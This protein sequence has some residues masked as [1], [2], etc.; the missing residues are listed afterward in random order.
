MSANVYIQ[1]ATIFS[2][3]ND[4]DSKQ[5]TY[6][7]SNQIFLIV[8]VWQILSTWLCYVFAKFACKI[9]IQNF[10]FA[11][12]V[13][14]T[15]PL[16]I[17]I[18]LTVSGLREMNQCALHGLFEDYLFFSAPP[19]Y[20]IGDFV[21]K[22]YA[23]MWLLTIVSQAWITKHIWSPKN[24]RNASTERLFIAPMYCSFLIDQCLVLNRRRDDQNMSL[25]KSVS[26]DEAHPTQDAELITF[27]IV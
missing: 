7:A 25:K 8:M 20:F 17:A 12:P 15:V 16:T 19:I 4:N 24:D 14:L 11:F 3:R 21:V 1:S 13:N 6:T 5:Y 9:Q 22:E 10:S 18:L 2:D 26:C 23:W 27:P